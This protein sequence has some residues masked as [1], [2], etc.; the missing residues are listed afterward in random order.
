MSISISL[1]RKSYERKQAAKRQMNDKKRGFS[2][3]QNLYIEEKNKD[4]RG[5]FLNGCLIFVI[6]S[7][8]IGLFLN[9]FGV[10]VNMPFLIA[11][12]FLISMFCAFL[13]LKQWV[14]ILGY[15]VIIFGFINVIRNMFYVLRGGFAYVANIF[16]ETI[17]NYLYLP[18]ERRYST[19]DLDMSYSTTITMALIGFVLILMLNILISEFRSVF[20]V[21]IFTF[22]FVS[23]VFYFE[24]S[25]SFWYLFM[26]MAGLATLLV[27][28]FGRHYEWIPEKKGNYKISEK[29]NRVYFRY[30]SSSK[31]NQWI[32]AC[33]AL[34][35][36]GILLILT[37]VYPAS[38]WEW[39]ESPSPLKE[40]SRD[41][42]SRLALQGFWGMFAK[43]K[44]AAGGMGN[45]KLGDVNLI[46][47][48]YMPDLY[49]QT[50]ISDIMYPIYMKG[51]YGTY[52]EYG[53]NEWINIIDT[54]DE[55]DVMLQN[56][57]TPPEEA[58]DIAD[59]LLTL[60]YVGDQILA[61][62][63]RGIRIYNQ[64]T[65]SQYAYL[66]YYMKNMTRLAGWSRQEDDEIGYQLHMGQT[67]SGWYHPMHVSSVPE[68]KEAVQKIWENHSETPAWSELEQ[69]EKDYREY[70]KE[71]YLHVPL[72]LQETLQ[73][74]CRE[75]GIEAGS[76][77]VVEDVIRVLGKNCEYNLMPGQTPSGKDFVTYFLMENKKGYC[78]YFATSAV[79]LYR[80][81]G[82]PARYCGGYVVSRDEFLDATAIREPDRENWVR[83]GNETVEVENIMA[84][85]ANAHA[86]VEIYVDGF[87]WYPVDPTPSDDNTD[88]GELYEE[89]TNGFM[90][91]LTNTMFGRGN[92]NRMKN[93]LIKIAIGLCVGILVTILSY[94]ILG[95][96][97]SKNRLHKFETQK[98]PESVIAMYQYL[99]KVYAFAGIPMSE[100]MSHYQYKERVVQKAL[101]SGEQAEK[102]VQIAEKAYYSRKG[103]DEEEHAAFL[104]ILKESRQQLYQNL[105][106]Y[107]KIHFKYVRLL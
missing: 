89:E 28:K 56:Y 87:G 17:E 82:I 94:L 49:I 53:E 97:I 93:T 86:W 43:D 25:I 51:F 65:S 92:M 70:A 84:T 59:R 5:L 103:T 66:P 35:S 99:K 100:G 11:M 33:I 8:A 69:V 76:E 20:W 15:L 64:A 34:L 107:R 9:G 23:M 45:G 24:K 54:R 106:W 80:T 26:Y 4:V 32:F 42:A 38:R 10:A 67:V 71:T 46:R 78:T 2:M 31:I 37:L 105:S 48:D 63:E 74:Y 77:D 3:V 12:L 95:I 13:Y 96:I 75:N 47:M 19:G 101:L 90:G 57:S 52:Y 88:Y 104:T 40:E 1:T 6:I 79:L 60:D 21:L 73:N 72:D 16:M 102:M 50:A 44:V 14:K 29:K 91:F 58:R 85:D 83:D 61:R 18:I 22:P 81:L 68:L 27:L 39:D 62:Y 36:G 55:W 41:F 7:G 98:Q 30:G